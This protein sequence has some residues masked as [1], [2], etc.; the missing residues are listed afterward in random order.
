MEGSNSSRIIC[1]SPQIDLNLVKV[2]KISSDL[3]VGNLTLSTWVENDDVVLLALV[4]YFLPTLGDMTKGKEKGKTKKKN[5]NQGQTTSDRVR[6][7]D[8][9]KF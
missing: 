7:Q 4:L 8:N 2:S 5:K 9:M 3:A 6:A 1:L